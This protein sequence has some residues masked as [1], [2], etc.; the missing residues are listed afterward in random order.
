MS[1]TLNAERFQE[2]FEGSPLIDVPGRMYNVEV[3]YTE[4]P[5]NDY[6]KSA[7]RTVL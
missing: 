6:F 7:V 4:S 5:E 2:Y 3:L 1:A